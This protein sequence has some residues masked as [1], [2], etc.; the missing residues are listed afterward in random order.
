MVD[1]D[2]FL[3]ALYVTVDEVLG[4]RPLARTPVRPP[5]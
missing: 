4:S 3:T 5:R 2:T 1:P